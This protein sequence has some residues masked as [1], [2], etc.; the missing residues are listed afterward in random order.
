MIQFKYFAEPM[1]FS[2]ITKQM[3]GCSICGSNEICF[4]TTGYYGTNSIECICPKCLKDGKL[5]EL[6]ICA[7]DLPYDFKNE[8]LTDQS[9]IDDLTN[10][11]VYRTPRLPTWQDMRWPIKN[12]DFCRFIKIAS[13]VDFQNP[14]DLFYSISSGYKKDKNAAQ[15]WDMLPSKKITSLEDGNYNVSFYLFD[16]FGEKVVTWDC[17]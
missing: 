1:N 11:I 5:I 15:L 4:D 6:D 16:S 7:N 12:G 14:E 8:S 9:N 3:D 13:K 10:E 17:N 2:F